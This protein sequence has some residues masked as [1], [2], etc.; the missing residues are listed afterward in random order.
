MNL[1]Q[2]IED[3]A[4]RSKEASF[5]LRSLVPETKTR[6]LCGIAD[7]I[8]RN[9]ER[10]RVANRIDCERGKKN[11][12][13]VAFLDRLL[14]DDS[15]IE[16]MAKSAREISGLED[17]V[18]KIVVTRRPQG[19]L[20]EK[21]RIP[22]G[23]V[24]MIYESRPNVTV[25]AACLCLKSSNAC[26]LRGGSDALESNKV[27][28]EIIKE[29][30][31]DAGIPKDAVGY[32]ERTEHEGVYHLVRQE[33]LVD[34][35]IP[36]GGE[37]LV[38]AVTEQAKVPVIKHYKG[39]CHL[40]IDSSASVDMALKIVKN[41]KVQ[42]PGTCNALETL[43]VHE[44]IKACLLPKLR[45]ALEGVELRGCEKTREIIPEAKSATEDDYYAEYLDMILAVRVVGSVDQAVR[46]IERYGSGHTD[47]IVSQDIGNID[48]FT[49]MVDSAVV[50]VNASTRLS[51]GGVFGLGAEIGI[52][53]DKL[54]ARGPMGI[55]ELV[56]YKWVVRGNGDI[57]R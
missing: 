27:L 17:P 43:L 36:R 10:I 1:E 26:I 4:R 54:H 57:R 41:A 32:V 9:R 13:S 6:A 44:D 42:R 49:G 53:T 34:L 29:A 19:F 39:V 52:S 35:A 48:R 51:D 5:A 20:L 12:L 2:Y 11:G 37:S 56:T 38:R 25:D 33:G 28:V 21:V 31:E 30:L 24:A 15:R 16:A 45:D 40:F 50:T 3:I 23:V 47:G 22:I 18:G 7:L 14:L 8:E 55:G 46:H